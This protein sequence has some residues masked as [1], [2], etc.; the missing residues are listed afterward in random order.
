MSYILSNDHVDCRVDMKD[1]NL[2]LTGKIKTI[3]TFDHAEIVAANPIDRRISYSGSG[4]PFPCANIAFEGTPNFIKV[5][6]DNNGEFSGVFMYPNSYYT[7]DGYTRVPPSIFVILKKEDSEPI[8]IHFELPQIDSI[9]N[10]R[11]LT[12]RNKPRQGPV[13]FDMKHDFIGVCD[14]EET[15]LRYRDAKIFN[16]LV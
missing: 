8:F 4:L 14:A 10:V 12:Y 11:T 1:G 3:H 7:E 15:M 2:F 5:T 16:D 13:T 9:L 6:S